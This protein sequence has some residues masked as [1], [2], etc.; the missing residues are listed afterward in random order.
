LLISRDSIAV[1]QL[2][3]RICVFFSRDSITVCQLWDRICLFFSN[4]LVVV[5]TII[6]MDFVVLIFNMGNFIFGKLVC[7]VTFMATTF[8][9]V[10]L[11]GNT[12]YRS[13][14]GRDRLRDMDRFWDSVLWLFLGIR[15]AFTFVLLGGPRYSGLAWVVEGVSPQT[16][17]SDSDHLLLRHVLVFHLPHRRDSVLHPNHGSL[18]V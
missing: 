5:F 8:I 6:M 4:Q 3:D 17:T 9:G 15:I 18:H 7:M 10:V 13:I 2:R 12:L 16:Y 14:I 11:A 1:C